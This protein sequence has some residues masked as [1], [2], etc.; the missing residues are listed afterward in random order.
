MKIVAEGDN[1]E[2]VKSESGGN[3]VMV[4]MGRKHDFGSALR[5]ED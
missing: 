2:K 4:I 5:E 3:V 1:V